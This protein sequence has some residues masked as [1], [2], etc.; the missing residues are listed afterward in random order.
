MQEAIDL[1]KEI[2][3]RVGGRLLAKVRSE[4]VEA[5]MGRASHSDS[6]GI[7]LDSSTLTDEVALRLKIDVDHTSKVCKTLDAMACL[8]DSADE[9]KAQKF[10][11]S[12]WLHGAKVKN[13]FAKAICVIVKSGAV[14]HVALAATIT[15]TFQKDDSPAEIPKIADTFQN[16]A[17]LMIALSNAHDLSEAARRAFEGGDDLPGAA[18]A[19]LAAKATADI[20]DIYNNCMMSPRVRCKPS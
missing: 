16:K 18:G 12:C 8:A 10:E 17:S 6:F 15:D 2:A 7:A 14:S 20:T 11:A 1:S 9:M 13:A 5:N 4:L 3:D 19:Q